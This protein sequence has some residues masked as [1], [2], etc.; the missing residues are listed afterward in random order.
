MMYWQAAT[1]RIM[2]C[3]V[4][5]PQL[6]LLIY[7]QSLS[8]IFAPAPAPAARYDTILYTPC[9]MKPTFIGR[10]TVLST[11]DY[12]TPPLSTCEGLFDT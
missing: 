6:T 2:L 1:L 3:F 4:H 11:S 10:R 8:M 7:P 9:T 12:L 5:H